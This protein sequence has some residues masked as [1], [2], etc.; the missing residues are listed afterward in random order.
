MFIYKLYIFLFGLKVAFCT[1]EPE[2]SIGF[3]KIKNKAS[4]VKTGKVPVCI[5]ESSGLA[6][7][8]QDGYYWTHNDSGGSPELYMIDDRGFIYD[9]LAIANA[10]NVDWEDLAKD[11]EG[12]IYVGDF[13]NNVGAR[14]TLKIY[15]SKGG[16]TEMLSFLPPNQT[17]KFDCEAFFWYQNQLYLFTKS[18]QKKIKKTILYRMPDTAG[19]HQLEKVD[20]L[21]L[22]TQVT[23]ADISP[24]NATFALMT[25]G[26]VLFFKVNEHQINFKTPA[27][28]IKTARKQTE[29]M[30]FENENEVFFTNEQRQ[31]FKIGLSSIK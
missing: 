12:F 28:C 19:T 7:A 18:W 1:C 29:A 6:K 17:E 24:T 10:E 26:K 15:K 3:K 8:W 4:I 30:V 2:H 23:A 22:N 11:T 16:H 5:N 14:D 21:E 20:E 27:F 31:L 9:T 13:G 25:Y